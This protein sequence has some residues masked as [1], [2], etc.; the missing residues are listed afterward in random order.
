M[1]RPVLNPSQSL[2]AE[3]Q[4]FLEHSFV[5]DFLAT[6]LADMDVGVLGYPG[7]IGMNSLGQEG[8]IAPL[9]IS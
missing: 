4:G 5:P 3:S 9:I 8:R 7:A 6:F 1:F 2:E